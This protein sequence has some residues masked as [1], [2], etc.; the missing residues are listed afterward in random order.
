MLG[1]VRHKSG[2]LYPKWNGPNS[3]Q[4]GLSE[5]SFQNMYI[6]PKWY[7]KKALDSFSTNGHVI[8]LDNSK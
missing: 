1:S 8:E 5:D 3:W 4:E 2:T 7:Q 6:F